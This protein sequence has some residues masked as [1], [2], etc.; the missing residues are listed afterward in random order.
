VVEKIVKVLLV[1][2]YVRDRQYS[3]LRFSELLESELGKCGHD[4][5]VIRPAVRLGRVGRRW[6]GVGKWLGYADKFLLFPARL[7]KA[8]AWADIVHVCD[9]SNSLYT[10][11]LDRFPHIVTCHDLLAVRLAQGEFASATRSLRR[12]CLGSDEVGSAARHGF[13]CREDFGDT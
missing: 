4:V 13:R 8:C 5:R 12:L 10:R 6:H 2:N 7:R 1:A 3:M 9:H 11:Y